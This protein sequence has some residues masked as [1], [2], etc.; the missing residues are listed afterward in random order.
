MNASA[1]PRGLGLMLCGCALCVS[2][3]IPP[4]CRADEPTAHP[5]NPR[6][7]EAVFDRPRGPIITSDGVVVA[8]TVLAPEGDRFTFQ[9]RYPTADLFANITGYFAFANGATQVE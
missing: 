2:L 7:I 3:R 9:R 6:Q 1:R 4:V 8:E 5:G